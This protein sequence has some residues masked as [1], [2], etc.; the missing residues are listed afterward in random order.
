MEMAGKPIY[1]PKIS[2]VN[3]N[4][5]V[6]VFVSQIFNCGVVFGKY[7]YSK[8]HKA[9]YCYAASSQQAA[10]ILQELLPYLRIKNSQAKLFL[11][12]M[13]IRKNSKSSGRRGAI[14][15]KPK[16][17]EKIVTRLNALNYRGVRP[18]K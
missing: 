13:H 6:L 2:I 16:T 7:Q 3:T 18:K 15:N 4:K 1:N 5:A 10:S 14:A 11:Q 17:Q 8:K 9:A 12:M